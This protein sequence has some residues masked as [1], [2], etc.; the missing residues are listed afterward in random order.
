M[1]GI[2]QCLVLSSMHNCLYN[3]R[4]I[5]PLKGHHTLHVLAVNRG[6]QPVQPLKRVIC[7]TL[8]SSGVVQTIS[9]L[10]RQIEQWRKGCTVW[11]KTLVAECC[12][13]N[14]QK[15]FG[16]SALAKTKLL[17]DWLLT[18]L[19]CSSAQVLYSTVYWIVWND[20]YKNLIIRRLLHNPQTPTK[21][22]DRSWSQSPL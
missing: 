1:V 3:D 13:K 4:L 19:K 7:T 22:T 14:W 2:T 15:K 20:E 10:D 12:P 6:Q 11:Y 21:Y 18:A 16:G 8:W 17:A 9:W 5:G